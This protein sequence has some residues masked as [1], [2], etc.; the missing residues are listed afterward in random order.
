MEAQQS[1]LHDTFVHLVGELLGLRTRLLERLAAVR[2]MQV[3]SCHGHGV[4]YIM[5]LSSCHGVSC[6]VSWSCH[7]AGGFLRPEG[8]PEEE[9][10]AAPRLRGGH[11]AQTGLQHRPAPVRTKA[12]LSTGLNRLIVVFPS[13]LV[14]CRSVSQLLLAV[15]ET[16]TSEIQRTVMLPELPPA[17]ASHT[18]ASPQCEYCA[19]LEE[20]AWRLQ[21]LI[22]CAQ[23]MEDFTEQSKLINPNE[24]YY[25][26]ACSLLR[27]CGRLWKNRR[28][29]HPSRRFLRRLVLQLPAGGR[30]DHRGRGG[31][32]Q[33]QLPEAGLILGG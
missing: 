14:V 16:V 21:N 12:R 3:P 10:G 11:S 7:R 30:H 9:A 32:G 23:K 22:A 17:P 18:A 33:G 6:H 29:H 1:S 26:T 13:P 5:V 15:R 2:S 27:F 24:I 28:R 8:E 31:R 25:T 19:G 4:S 20:V